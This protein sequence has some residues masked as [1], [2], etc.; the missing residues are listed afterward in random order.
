MKKPVLIAISGVAVA[1][2]LSFW[3]A[4]SFVYQPVTNVHV[5][6]ITRTDKGV[7]SYQTSIRDDQGE[8]TFTTPAPVESILWTGNTLILTGKG[9]ANNYT[10]PSHGMGTLQLS[11]MQTKKVHTDHS[12]SSEGHGFSRPIESGERFDLK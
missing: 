9:F 11:L 6:T 2:V 1:T 3:A 8:R 12:D 4:R 10:P 7:T 5:E